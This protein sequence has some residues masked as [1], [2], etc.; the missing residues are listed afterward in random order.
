MFFLPSNPW[1]RGVV[2][3]ACV[4]A[5]AVLVPVTVLFIEC[6][7]ALWPNKPAAAA[8]RPRL[9]VLVPA[10]N[11]SAGIEP[12]LRALVAQMGAHDRVVVIAD[13]CSDDT[14][15]CARATGVTVIERQDNERRGKGY[16][17]DH[18]MRFLAN[19]PPEVVVVVDADCLVEPGAL[20]RLACTAIANQRPVQAVYLMEPPA[21]P[22]PKD[23]VSALAFLVKNWVRP[24]GLYTLGFPG[25]LTGTGMAFPWK[26][27]Q[28]VSLASGNIVEDMQLSMDLAILGA[29]TLFVPTAKVLGLLP[30]QQSAA[31]SQRT[32]WEHG[33]LRTMRTQVP[34]LLG[35]A[36]K[37]RRLDLAVIALDLLVPPLSLLVM[38]WGA[39]TVGSVALALVTHA[40][41]PSFLCAMAG[42]MIAVAIL[43]A[44]MKYGRTMLPAKALLAVPFYVLWKIPLYVSY[45][46]RPQT[47]W[48]RTE[49]D[50]PTKR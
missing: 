2:V 22:Q 35:Q 39:V 12:V 44:W 41:L 38:L 24:S 18:G 26:V 27:L 33:H 23:A 6:V 21:Q 48:V 29:P 1:E 31:K 14:A 50:A 3:L 7:A 19:D 5:L 20:E 16:A 10:H 13:N 34:R 32:R 40:W 36:I 4:A 11:E 15:A 9:A 8:P 25:I 42:A 30:Q 49:R 28:Q 47:K 17:L 43:S 45:V 37:Q 46:V